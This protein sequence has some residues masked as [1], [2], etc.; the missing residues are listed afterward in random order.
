MVEQPN[1]AAIRT[2]RYMYAEHST[3]EKELY[4]LRG[5]PYELRSRHNDPAYANAR[6]VLANRLHKL[7][8]CSGASCRVRQADPSP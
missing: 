6:S 5:D 3:G 7:E 1:F 2:A 4:D 8:T